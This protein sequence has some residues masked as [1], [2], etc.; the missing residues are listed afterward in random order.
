MEITIPNI[1]TT[2]ATPIDL[3]S[4]MEIAV[5]DV[6]SATGYT[7]C[8]VKLSSLGLTPGKKFLANLKQTGTSTPTK[9]DLINSTGVTPTLSR[10]GVGSYKVEFIGLFSNSAKLSLHPFVNGEDG[11]VTFMPV[12]NAGAIVGYYTIYYNDIDALLIKTYDASFVAADISTL[13][14]ANNNLPI[15]FTIFP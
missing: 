8:K 5:P 15:E 11:K 9:T 10:P 7:S 2:A 3:D 1:P 12:Y 13:L 4:W 6:S 14:G